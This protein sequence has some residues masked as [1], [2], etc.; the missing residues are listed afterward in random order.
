MRRMLQ[1]PQGMKIQ[2]YFGCYLEL[3]NYL[4]MFPLFN[5]AN[6]KMPMDEI[7]E[8]AKFAIPSLWQRQF[9]LQGFN[10]VT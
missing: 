9:V 3:N 2:D 1:K 6:Q 7:L 5:G 8:H 4:E 10:T